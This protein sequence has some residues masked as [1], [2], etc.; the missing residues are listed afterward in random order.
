MNLERS[1]SAR[2]KT[3]DHKINSI[4]NEQR[5]TQA[6]SMGAVQLMERDSL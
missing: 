1:Y 6:L 2:M 5:N 4:V 3:P